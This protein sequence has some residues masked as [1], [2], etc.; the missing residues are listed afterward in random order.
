MT[1]KGVPHFDTS[2]RYSSPKDELQYLWRKIGFYSF[3]ITYFTGFLTVK[4]IPIGS[5]L[6]FQSS[7]VI[8]CAVV[9][10][11]ILLLVHCAYFLKKRA[12]EMQFNAKM[13]GKWIQVPKPSP[14]SAQQI[15][16]WRP[17]TSY[18]QGTIV[19][20][21][22]A[23]HIRTLQAWQKPIWDNPANKQQSY[24]LT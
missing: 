9:E 10:L 18:P 7:L 5:Q 13:S 14:T 19:S 22:T 16:E 1:L 17:H 11:L 15:Q 2:K 24:H 20:L 12:V 21:S 6:Y 23:R 3:Q 4:F 8:V